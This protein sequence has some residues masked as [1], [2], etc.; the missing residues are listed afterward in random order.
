MNFAQFGKYT[1]LKGEQ[2][3]EEEF[4]K[5]QNKRMK[6]YTTN[7]FDAGIKDVTGNQFHDGFGTPS[8]EIENSTSL[9]GQVTNP[10]IR[11]EWGALPINSAGLSRSGP[12]IEHSLVKDRK[13]CNPED[14]Q[15]QNRSF[16]TLDINPNAT[17]KSASYRQGVDTRND[18]RSDYL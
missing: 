6:Y 2:R 9:R 10:K 14:S 4:V 16:Y 15:F 5:H 18:T 1:G 3:D 17:Q 11:H 8:Q 12:T 7:F 13:S